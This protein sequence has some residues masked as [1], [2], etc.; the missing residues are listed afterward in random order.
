[1]SNVEAQAAMSLLERAALTVRDMQDLPDH[2]AATIGML[3]LSII[4]M[5]KSCPDDEAEQVAQIAVLMRR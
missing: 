5:V 2:T 4:R 1:M 3:A